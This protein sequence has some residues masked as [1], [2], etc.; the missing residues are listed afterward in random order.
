MQD[1]TGQQLIDGLFDA[2]EC[3]SRKL[4][5]EIIARPE[6]T[7]PLLVDIVRDESLHFF[8]AKGGGWAPIHAMRLLGEIGAEEGIEAL[9]GLLGQGSDY[10]YEETPVALAMI[11]PPALKP[12]M[13]FGR[14]RTN[15]LYARINACHA[16]TYLVARHSEQREAVV[17]FLREE[18]GGDGEDAPDYY[19]FIVAYLC[20]LV[21]EEAQPDIERAFERGIVSTEVVTLDDVAED[22]ASGED[23]MLQQARGSFLDKYE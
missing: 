10:L 14:D 19:A 9:L 7:V 15:E 4:V 11:G 3:P 21:A 23:W 22:M 8:E 2:G 6:E 16:L 18:L 20:D 5:E 17:S 1:K 12:L 13:D